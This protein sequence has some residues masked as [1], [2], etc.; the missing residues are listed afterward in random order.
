MQY[1]WKLFFPHNHNGNVSWVRLGRGGGGGTAV[2]ENY[3]TRKV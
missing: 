2:G 1:N 3:V